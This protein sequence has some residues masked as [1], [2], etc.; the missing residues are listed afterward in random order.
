MKKVFMLLALIYC[1]MPLAMAA[2][3]PP[4]VSE[5]YE[6]DEKSLVIRL[7]ASD[8]PGYA[9]SYDIDDE[10]VMAF[11]SDLPRDPNGIQT[12]LFHAKSDGEALITF[13]YEN[14]NDEES[15]PREIY[16]SIAISDAKIIDVLMEDLSYDG[17]ADDAA[18]TYY[19][20][21]TGGVKVPLTADMI[22]TKTELGA[23]IESPD[24]SIVTLITYKKDEDPQSLFDKLDTTEKAAALFEDPDGNIIVSNADVERDADPPQATVL[25]ENEIGI[26][27]YEAYQ[28]PEGG[29][30]YVETTYAIDLGDMDGA[31]EGWD[32]AFEV[33]TDFTEPSDG[34][35]ST[36]T[37]ESAS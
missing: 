16:Y 4:I 14:E 2:D 27:V 33:E 11:Q 37:E 24:G 8:E 31:D 9:W 20:G 22:Q 10:Q 6:A 7:W 15:V 13:L 18:V 1:L 34:E 26:V 25:M 19:E 23:R 3:A 29:V 32:E 12:W 28:A 17:D 5:G 36:E 30:L 21:E 35:D